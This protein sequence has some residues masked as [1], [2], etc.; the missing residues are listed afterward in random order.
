MKAY[1]AGLSRLSEIGVLSVLCG[2]VAIL[3]KPS[4]SQAGQLDYVRQSQTCLP[5]SSPI[6][7]RIEESALQQL[8]GHYHLTV[9][10]DAGGSRKSAQGSLDLWVTNLDARSENKVNFNGRSDID[11]SALGPVEL[12]YSPASRDPSA[13]GVRG[14]YDRTTQQLVLQFGGLIRDRGVLFWVNQADSLGFTGRWRDAGRRVG[15]P[16]G[17]YCA[18]KSKR[19]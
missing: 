18:E 3:S 14:M 1:S 19:H 16:G 4:S 7:A 11:F 12:V 9:V 8:T 15:A 10:S 6:G 5:D 13:P 17:F 2:V